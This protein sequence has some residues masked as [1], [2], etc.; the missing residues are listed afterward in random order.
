MRTFYPKNKATY[1]C[2]LL[3]KWLYYALVIALFCIVVTLIFDGTIHWD[4]VLLWIFS[5]LLLGSFMMMD[6]SYGTKVKSISIDEDNRMVI[7][8][9]KIFLF[10]R[11]E[12][13]ISFDDFEYAFNGCTVYP[14]KEKIARYF[15]PSFRSDLRILDKKQHKIF[16]RD[17]YGWT[18]DQVSEIAEYFSQI[19]PPK[20]F[21]EVAPW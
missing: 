7:I 12:K 14:M 10:F 15:L 20:D 6:I 1:K 2:F 18:I 21:D 3:V 4:P 9:Y 13:R 5:Y 17:T 8:Q 11:K 16:F 19:K